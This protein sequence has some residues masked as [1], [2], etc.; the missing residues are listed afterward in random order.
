MIGFPF[1]SHSSDRCE[2]RSVGLS[3]R[4]VDGQ[5]A[6]RQL[7]LA[8]NCFTMSANFYRASKSRLAC[9]FFKLQNLKSL[10]IGRRRALCSFLCVEIERERERKFLCKTDHSNH[11]INEPTYSGAGRRRCCFKLSPDCVCCVHIITRARIISFCR[12]LNCSY[13]LLADCRRALCSCRLARSCS[14]HL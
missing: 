1:S 10:T 7:Q 2:T 11:T 14:L 12:L 6:A 5:G 13:K 8:G 9:A 4:L 3:G